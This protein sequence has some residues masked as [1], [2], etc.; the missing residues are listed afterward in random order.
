MPSVVVILGT[1]PEAIKL[2]PVVLAAR[3]QPGF[4][5]VVCNTGQ[6]ADMTAGVLGLFGIEPDIYFAI[7]KPRQSLTDITAAVLQAL[8]PVLA[9]RR[10]D[11]L[12]VQGD[13]TSAFAAALAAFYARIPVAHVEAGLRTGDI[14]APWPEEMNRLLI[15]DVARLHFAPLESNS[16]NLR[17]EGVP[18]ERIV[19]T[20]NTG[21]DALKW[22]AGR[23]TADKP[24]AERAQAALDATKVAAL[25]ANASAQIVLIT[26]HRRES[27]GDG[28]RSI[29]AALADLA[30]RFPERHFVYAVHPNPEV[31]ETV[32]R[33]LGGK[34]ATVHL[35]EP[36]DYLP[37]V[38]LMS[39][40]ELIL[41]DSGGI[42]EEAPSIGKRV[43]VLRRVTER[44]EGVE[45]GLIRLAG[46]DRAQ[47]VADA[48]AALEGRWSPK[49][50]QSDVY[51]DGRAAERIIEAL[52]AAP[53]G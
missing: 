1:R 50:T 41:T 33:E 40:A 13:T 19:V 20:G 4:R 39:R 29:C 36:L 2:A 27:F 51:G 11:W 45:T 52:A 23:L 25:R 7:M 31:R 38:L 9:A 22:I 24:L 46:T 18:A 42:Q 47:I 44:V 53:R 32:Q 12:V 16:A 30:R 28:F 48:T 37:F 21:I 34:L 26:G 35:I 14:H 3:A 15:T 17:R 6:H 10:P 5:V 43:I 49:L 8:E